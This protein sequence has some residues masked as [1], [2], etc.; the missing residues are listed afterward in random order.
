[1]INTASK[2]LYQN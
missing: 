1:M 2:Y